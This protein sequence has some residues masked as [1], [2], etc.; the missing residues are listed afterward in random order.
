MS[1]YATPEDERWLPVPGYEGLYSISDFGRVRLERYRRIAQLNELRGKTNCYLRI[2]FSKDGEAKEFLVH[3]LVMV[4]FAPIT[5]A[6]K[7]Q[8]NHIDGNGR[9]NRRSNL[10][11][12]TA[13]QNARHSVHVLGNKG[14]PAV[15]SSGANCYARPVERMLLTGEVVERYDAIVDVESQGYSKRC[16]CDVCRRRTSRKTHKGFLWR[17]ATPPLRKRHSTA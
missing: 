7:L 6:E 5:N 10:E 1:R 11:W 8:V 13:S 17:Y 4:A 14:L 16:V 3:R 9:N 12:V 15:L 2:D